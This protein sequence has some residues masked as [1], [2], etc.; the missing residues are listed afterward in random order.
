MVTTGKRAGRACGVDW[1]NEED[2]R[3][4]EEDWRQEAMYDASH[5]SECSMV[6]T[7]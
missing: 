2:R 5:D 1:T 6:C 7:C 4:I 3:V